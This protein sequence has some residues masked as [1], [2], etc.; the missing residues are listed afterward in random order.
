MKALIIIDMIQAY[1]KDINDDKKIVS[2]QLKL[3]DAFQKKKL[4]VIL[5]VPGKGIKLMKGDNPIGLYLWGNELEG[6]DKRKEGE[7]LQDLIVELQKIKWDKKVGKPEYSCFFNTDLEKYCNSKKITELYICGIYSG[8]CLH[9][10]GVD[11]QYRRI[12]PILV[13]DA[14]TA[15]G[16]MIHKKNCKDFRQMVGKVSTT[17]EVLKELNSRKSYK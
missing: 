11:A 6:D 7:K 14:S 17:K 10:T 12:W 5:A 15:R 13:I 8:C 3:I 4:P 16:K 1:S 9:Y 2:N